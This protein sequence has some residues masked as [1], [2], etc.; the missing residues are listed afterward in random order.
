MP[1]T[2]S[3]SIDPRWA[4]SF[5]RTLSSLA[6]IP[7][8]EWSAA[9]SRFRQVRVPRDGFFY[10][11]G[12]RPDR[13][14]FVASGLFRVFF[15]TESGDERILVFRGEGRLLS[16]FTASFSGG[17]SWYGIQALEDSVLLCADADASD[18]RGLAECWRRVYSRYMEL[19]FEE[20]GRREREFL[21]DDAETRY[22]NFLERYP[23]LEGRLAQYH[24]A[25][26]LGITPVALS[27][28]RK[29][30]RQPPLT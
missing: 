18:I 26:Y 14:G 20:K 23:G 3:D 24:V 7:E 25:S 4:S 12:D 2:R 22:R 29:R 19:L 8:E 5:R 13:L 28:I 1:R 17:E 11:P 15:S 27:R 21:S 16:G 9:L 30:M 6:D 10:R